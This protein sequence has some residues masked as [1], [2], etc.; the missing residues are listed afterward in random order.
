MHVFLLV[1]VVQFIQQI[2]YP[3]SPKTK[4]CPFVVGN[5]CSMDHP[6]DQPLCLVLDFQ[7]IVHFATLWGGEM[8]SFHRSISAIKADP[9]LDT[10]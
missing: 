7:G 4:L 2:I 6:K 5:S 10:T 3:G 9:T 8:L 1:E